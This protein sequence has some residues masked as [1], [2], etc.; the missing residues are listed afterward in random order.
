[1][2][3]TEGVTLAAS[4]TRDND[5]EAGSSSEGAFVE[6]E[7]GRGLRCCVRS[8][9]NVQGWSVWS[10]FGL[11]IGNTDEKAGLHSVAADRSVSAGSG[12]PDT[13]YFELSGEAL[14]R[15]HAL[16]GAAI[17]EARRRGAP[18]PAL[19]GMHPESTGAAA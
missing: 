1:M 8:L 18:L 14:V 5:D 11:A 3:A 9:A 13:A 4:V 19:R 2:S 16:V 10:G 12:A 17:E 6:L 7:D 15:L